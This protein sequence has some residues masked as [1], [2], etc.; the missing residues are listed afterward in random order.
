MTDLARLDIVYQSKGGERAVSVNNQLTKS[1]RRAEK[2]QSNLTQA[3]LDQIPV[4]SDLKKAV[5]ALVASYG[6]KETLKIADSYKRANDRLKLLI[7]N[8][9][10]YERIQRKLQKNAI[11]T[12]SSF[13]ASVEV[14]QRA[15]VGLKDLGKSDEDIAKVVKGVQQL[16]VIGGTATSSMNAGLLQLGQAFSAGTVRTEEFNSILENIPFLAKSAADGF[17]ITQGQLRSLVLEGKVSSA[18][19]FEAISSQLTKV[20]EDFQKLPNNLAKATG[21]FRETAKVFIGEVNDQTDA[22]ERLSNFVSFLA[23][24]IDALAAAG[25]AVVILK[26]ATSIKALSL[27]LV[28]NPFGLIVA[29]VAAVAFAVVKYSKEIKKGLVAFQAGITDLSARALNAIGIISDETL[30]FAQRRVKIRVDNMLNE[31]NGAKKRLQN[32]D[33]SEI[34]PFKVKGA[35]LGTEELT[36]LQ[37]KF[38]KLAEELAK[39]NAKVTASTKK[40]TS[41]EK[42]R[43]EALKETNDVVTDLGFTFESAFEDAILSG[44]KLGDVLASLAQDLARLAVRKT[45]TEPLFSSFS[46]SGLAKGL[47]GLF[48]GGGFGGFFAK[49]GVTNRPSIFGEAGPEAAV[50]LPDGRNIPVKLMGSASQAPRITI[51][52]MNS[53]NNEVRANVSPN[54]RDITVIIDE[55]VARN[56]NTPGSKT[57]NSIRSFGTAGLSRG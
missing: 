24:N 29:G 4:V 15:R 45:I 26:I 16:G 38:R 6:I 19:F 47:T 33:L 41:A 3:Q 37:K 54:G 13:E 56:I 43:T 20:D 52:N 1:G 46:G 51:N 34:K 48:T 22:I 27:A 17:G 42:E 21:Q 57:F 32:E 53:S 8:V 11:E 36:E 9:T 44:R 55:A 49:G 39:K 30:D 35:E 10:E 18:D 50:P 28:A 25:L 23:K 7:G 2:A 14:F 31:I 5:T 12:G 40:A